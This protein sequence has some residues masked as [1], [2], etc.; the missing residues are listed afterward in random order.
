MMDEKKEL[1][2][3]VRQAFLSK[4]AQFMPKYCVPRK[5]ET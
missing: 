5:F 4:M 1:L 3:K 2:E